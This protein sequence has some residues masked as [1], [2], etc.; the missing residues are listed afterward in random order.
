M[1]LCKPDH[2]E[3]VATVL[4]AGSVHS[5]IRYIFALN[6]NIISITSVAR[7]SSK[8]IMSP[9]SKP[10]MSL[11]CSNELR[12]IEHGMGDDE[13]ARVEPYRSVGAD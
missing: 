6:F 5:A 7:C 13:R 4:A 12:E 8:P 11:S 10:G 3:P 1:V 9:L 2:S